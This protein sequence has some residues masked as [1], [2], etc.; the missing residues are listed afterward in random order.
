MDLQDELEKSGNWLFRWRSYLPI[1]FIGLM[2]ATI[3]EYQYPEHSEY[4]DHLLEA[5]CLVI[6]F[7]GL[8]IRILTIGYA[9]AG[10]SGRNTAKQMAETLNTT[11]LYSVVR[12]PLYLGNF[13]IYLGIVLFVHL[14]WLTVI[15]VLAFWLYYERIIFAEEAFLTKKFGRVFIDWAEITPI[16]F[17]RITGFRKPVLPFSFKNVLK[18]EYNGFF[19]IIAVMFLLEI[20][21]E[22]FAKGKF[23]FDLWWVIIFW[24][25]FTVWVTLRMLKKHTSFLD[26]KGR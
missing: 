25:G 22:F 6:S 23:D 16:I 10:T 7:F 4:W 1:A 15:Y 19:A 2:L 11:G 5:S 21:G 26:V 17:P 20:V 14:W 12:N 24:I 8:G 18:R 9:P 3:R 13:F